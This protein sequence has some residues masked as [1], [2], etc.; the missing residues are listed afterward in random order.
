MLTDV[1]ISFNRE[2]QFY[3]KIT[4]F[5]SNERYIK[6]FFKILKNKLPQN[7]SLCQNDVQQS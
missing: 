5:I 3:I 7:I 6:L 4:F 1:Y 2:N